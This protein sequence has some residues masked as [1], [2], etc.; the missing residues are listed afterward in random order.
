MKWISVKE[1]LP[2]KE[3]EYFVASNKRSFLASVDT[4]ENGQWIACEENCC[5]IIH[6]NN[7]THWMEI[8]RIEEEK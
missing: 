4:W 1:R 6:A 8:P 7:I 3:G 5:W 2:E